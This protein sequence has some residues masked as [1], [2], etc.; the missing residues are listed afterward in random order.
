MRH[1]NNVRK[2]GRTTG[3]R[4]ALMKS[5]ALSLITH[6]RITTTLAKAKELRPYVEKIVT[7]GK[8]ANTGSKR[9]VI[10]KLINRKT[11][12]KKLF[13]EIVP[14]YKTRNGGYTRILKLPPRLSDSSKMA[15]IEFV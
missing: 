13:D 10:A 1:H 8:T 3:A 5:L 11:E 2:F 15:I 6:G 12:V 7:K 9:L 14:K 4:S